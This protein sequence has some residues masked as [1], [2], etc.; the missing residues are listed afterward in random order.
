MECKG[1][2]DLVHKVKS[3]P[4]KKLR[5]FKDVELHFTVNVAS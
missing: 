4:M 5:G 1:D 3:D 2:A